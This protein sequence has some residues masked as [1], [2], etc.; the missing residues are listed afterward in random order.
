MFDCVHLVIVVARSFAPEIIAVVAAPIPPFSVV[1][2]P[3]ASVVEMSAVVVLSGRLLV[4]LGS[5]NVFSDEL[6]CVIG[7][8][9]ILGR[10]EDFSDRG[11]P[12]AQPL[13]SQGFVKRKTFL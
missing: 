9:V 13:T 5:P 12:L 10:G 11:R 7:V 6:F 1:V 2:A 4:L 3:K 8:G